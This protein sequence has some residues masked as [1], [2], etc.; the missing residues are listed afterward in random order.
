MLETIGKE[1]LPQVKRQV[2][3]AI[4]LSSIGDSTLTHS[5]GSFMI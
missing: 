2:L 4:H 3:D 1:R 5:Y